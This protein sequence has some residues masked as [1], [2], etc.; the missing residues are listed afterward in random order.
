LFFED[1]A[2]LVGIPL[3]VVGV[4]GVV[5]AAAVMVAYWAKPY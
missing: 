1:P 5:V 4:T 2:L 3:L